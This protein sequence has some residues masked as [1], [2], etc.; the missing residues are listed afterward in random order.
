MI[1]RWHFIRSKFM[2]LF[3]ARLLKCREISIARIYANGY[4]SSAP[5]PAPTTISAK[6]SNEDLATKVIRGLWGN[7][8]ERK[9]RLE[10][11]RLQLLCR[12]TD[13]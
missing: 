2:R 1:V 3:A 10:G 8:Q 11:G 4:T 6:K 13:R 9:N 7:G 5:A 12:S